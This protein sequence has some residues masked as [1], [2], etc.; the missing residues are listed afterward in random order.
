MEFFT[1]G[2]WENEPEQE[3]F[4]HAELPCVVTRNDYMGNLCGYVGVPPGHPLYSKVKMRDLNEIHRDGLEK[5]DGGWIIEPKPDIEPNMHDLSWQ[6][7]EVE[8]HGG[9]TYGALGD[10]EFGRKAGFKWFGFDCA[11]AWDYSPPMSKEV[12]DIHYRITGRVGPG[13][14]EEYRNWEYVK[15]EV[16]HLA[17]Q[18]AAMW[19]PPSYED[20]KGEHD[21]QSSDR[22]QSE[23]RTT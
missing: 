20:W 12:A 17:E 14:H 13:E 23:Q 8:V 1:E 3:E 10:G 21:R 19:Q 9:L 22:E 6:D 15:K 11:H 5:P 4:D 7:V 16:E 18:L 2:E